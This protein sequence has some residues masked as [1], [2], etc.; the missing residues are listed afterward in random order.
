MRLETKRLTIRPIEE[1]D[2]SALVEILT[3][4]TVSK[5]Y[6]VPPLASQMEAEQ[7][8]RRFVI[9]SHDENRLALA[10]DLEGKLIGFIND[11][12]QRDGMIELGYAIHPD[13]HNRGYMTEAL[14]AML[15]ALFQQGVISVVA[16]AFAENEASMRVMRK[17][18]MRRLTQTEDIRYRGEVHVCVYYAAANPNP[19]YDDTSYGGIW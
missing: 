13:Y 12:E 6:M 11:V 8:A 16:G 2:I 3:D 1:M 4:E 19:F 15:D 5:T 18:G 17:C 7:L 14:E 9:A 10:I